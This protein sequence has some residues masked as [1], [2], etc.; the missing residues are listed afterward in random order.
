MYWAQFDLTKLIAAMEELHSLVGSIRWFNHAQ[1]RS[2]I[3]FLHAVLAD[4]KGAENLILSFSWESKI[5]LLVLSARI[6]ELR[7]IFSIGM[8]V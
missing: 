4:K 8:R 5:L 6:L 7:D 3:G 2:F 1:L